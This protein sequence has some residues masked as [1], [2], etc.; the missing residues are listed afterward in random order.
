MEIKKPDFKKNWKVGLVIIILLAFFGGAYFYFS[1]NKPKPN[2]ENKKELAVVIV[3]DIHA[4]S[5]K[6]SHK[7]MASVFPRDFAKNIQPA[8]R[9]NPDLIITLGD[10]VDDNNECHPWADELKATL[11]SFNVLWAKGNHD[12][13]C[14]PVFNSQNYYYHD[15]DNA[16]WRIVML[17]DDI[18]IDPQELTWL[19]EALRT[20]KKVLI[21]THVPFF[22]P[23]RDEDALLP[24]Y[25]NA[26]KVIAESGNVQYVF[27]GHLH[28]R[29]W[30]KVYDGVHYY[31]LPSVSGDQY[32]QYFMKLLLK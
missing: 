20:D 1:H 16:G 14:F 11:S 28:S 17:D 6:E 32:P 24:Q 29:L 18:D 19:K 3:T 30:D 9:S 21:V 2:I 10:N 22:S 23:S 25:A 13:D 4:G 7:E 27:M 12:K 15:Y 5:A 26:E 8:I 31:I